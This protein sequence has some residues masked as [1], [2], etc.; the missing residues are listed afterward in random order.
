MTAIYA[1]IVTTLLVIALA[2]GIYVFGWFTTPGEHANNGFRVTVGELQ[3]RLA[4]PAE[5]WQFK[6]VVRVPSD[7]N[8]SDGLI[9][10]RPPE[11]ITNFPALMEAK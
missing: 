9:R 4:E 1:A 2:I 10:I 8:P 6:G 5:Y 11:G 7:W 3:A